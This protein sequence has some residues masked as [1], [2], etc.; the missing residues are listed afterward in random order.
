MNKCKCSVARKMSWF[1]T[2]MLCCG[3]YVSPLTVYAASD[4]EYSD[5]TSVTNKG[6]VGIVDISLEQSFSEDEIV[7]LPNQTVAMDSSVKNNGQPAW[8]RVKI[9]Y[10]VGEGVDTEDRKESLMELDDKLVSFANENW[11]K[12][13]S[14]YY[15]KEALQNGE[16]MPFTNSITF[17]ADW[18]NRMVNSKFGV[19]LVAEAIQE[20]NFTPDFT[21]EDPWHGAVIEA[22]DAENYQPKE[23]GNNTF[24]VSY[25]DGVEGLIHT[26]DDFFSNWGD[27][28]P[29]DVLSGTATIDNHMSIPVKIF[30]E[31]ESSDDAELLEKLSI[32]ITNGEDVVYEGPLSGEVSPKV[33]LKQYEMD[34]MTEFKYEL[35]VPEDIDNAYAFKEF[36]VLWTFSAEEVIEDS[37]PQPGPDVRE[38]EPDDPPATLLPEQSP[39]EPDKVVVPVE[40]PQPEPKETEKEPVSP[41][42][43]VMRQIKENIDTGDVALFGL[44]GVAIVMMIVLAVMSIRLSHQKK[45]GKH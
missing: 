28:M 13:G 41:V 15:L 5:S 24:S 30:F 45:G 34:E 29:G 37:E 26:G 1:L 40:K 22:F 23:E 8:V 35:T 2:L 39:K 27:L 20:K 42:E 10:P 6:R 19:L 11:E 9:E 44:V 32:K 25:K 4:A 12:I 33:L 3:L 18:D 7:I 17:P 14:Y 38:P 16:E 36:E 43:K 31:T 21:A